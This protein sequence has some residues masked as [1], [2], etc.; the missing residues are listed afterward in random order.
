LTSIAE[1]AT[2]LGQLNVAR[3]AYSDA[4]AGNEEIHNRAEAAYAR[5]G[6]ATVYLQ[7]A[8]FMLARREASAAGEIWA[9]L[10]DEE[11]GINAALLSAVID[12]EEGQLANRGADDRALS[13]IDE[14]RQRAAKAGLPS[15]EASAR[16]AQTQWLLAAKRTR[17]AA[18]ILGPASRLLTDN[19]SY[20]VQFGVRLA[21]IDVALAQRSW[22]KATAPST[23]R[24]PRRGSR[25]A[26]YEAESSLRQITLWLATAQNA[27]A[28]ALPRCRQDSSR[29]T[30]LI[31]LKAVRQA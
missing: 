14:L 7:Q 8:N 24:W 22:K 23:A 25:L 31:R 17:E 27:R 1:T 6:L 16:V 29:R 4:L 10:S 5:A 21:E 28:P 2:D 12:F 18:P 19:A 20:G 30:E 13:R 9:S 11:G 26:L 15:L 3:Q